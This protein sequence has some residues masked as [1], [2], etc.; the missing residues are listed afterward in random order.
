MAGTLRGVY[1][2]GDKAKK[3]VTAVLVQDLPSGGTSTLS[4]E[5]YVHRGLEPAD[6][7]LPW[8]EDVEMKPAEPHSMR[9]LVGKS[10]SPQ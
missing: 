4:L 10:C 7:T 8:Q 9:E 6:G 3:L 2:I 5:D 1:L